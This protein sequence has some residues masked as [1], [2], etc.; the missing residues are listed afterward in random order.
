MSKHTLWV[1]RF[2]PDTLEG[3]L[4][5]ED[6]ISSLETWI[7]KNDFPNLLLYGS[8]GTG[9]TTAAK[10]VVK[11]INCDFIYLNCSDENGIDTIRDKV[12]QFA[13][14][15][16]FKPLKV[17]I[18]DEADF[19][20]INAQA[21][22]RNVI[23]SFSLTTRFIFTCNFVERIID[24]L[25]SR[26]TA[27][28]LNT[29]EA[30]TI[31]KRLKEILDIEQVEY[32]IKDVVEIVKKTYPDI[33][34]ALNLIQGCSINGDG[35][36]K[37]IIKNVTSSNYIEQIINEI[38][39]KKKTSF[40]TVR[41]IIADNNINDFTGLYKELHNAYSTPEATIIIEEYL[42]HSTTISD[43]EICFMGCVAKLLNI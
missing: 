34:R 19:L 8:P 6:F 22:L 17:V 21:A 10:L 27:F 42:F 15:A 33:R 32:D 7:S 29:P 25:Q 37:L 40:N 26:L 11:N 38:K 9:K 3:Y 18:L 2:R 24:P 28:A 13:S 16:T 35:K 43:K 12:K 39:S 23:E 4:G 41:Q 1:E 36:R 5:N 14:G 30:K 20:T 31:A